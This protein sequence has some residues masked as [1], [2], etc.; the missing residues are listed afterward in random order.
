MAEYVVDFL[1][2]AILIVTITALN[3][4]ITNFIGESLFGGKQKAQYKDATA[5]TQIGW[6]PVGG[7]RNK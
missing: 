4:V 3:G 2:V 1:L 6:K 5:K 7:N